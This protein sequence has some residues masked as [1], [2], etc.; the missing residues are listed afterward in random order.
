MKTLVLRSGGGLPAFDI[1]AGMWLA[2]DDAGIRVD[3]VDGSSA[4]GVTGIMQQSGMTAQ[5]FADAIRSFQTSDL[6]AYRTLWQ[7]RM[8]FDNFTSIL[9]PGPIRQTL[10]RILPADW[11]KYTACR[12]N[13]TRFSNDAAT[14]VFDPA[15]M[16]TPIDAAMATMAIDGL[17][18]A[19]PSIDGDLMGDGAYSANLPL[20]PDWTAYDRVFLLIGSGTPGQRGKSAFDRILHA[21]SLLIGANV[22]RVLQMV[23]DAPNVKVLYPQVDTDMLSFNHDLIDQMRTWTAQ[24]LAGMM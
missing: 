1:Y 2:F 15:I 7:A 6:V 24:Q 9:D 22:Q 20:P 4:G 5:M 8:F 10:T 14:N 16:P 19:I 18:C 13:A 3:A 23:Q 21:K 12:A 17:W 11:S